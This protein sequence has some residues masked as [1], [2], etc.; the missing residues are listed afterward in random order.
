[1]IR[2]VG[3]PD[4]GAAEAGANDGA[5]EAGANDGD[6]DGTAGGPPTLLPSGAVRNT[7]R[8]AMATTITATAASATKDSR[9]IVRKRQGNQLERRA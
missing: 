5:A 6:A 4:D 3:D 9:S 2:A 8:P 1:M 7:A